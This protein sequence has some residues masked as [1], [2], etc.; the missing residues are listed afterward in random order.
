MQAD[1]EFDIGGDAPVI[2]AHWAGFVDLRLQ[3]ERAA[4][5]IEAAAF[6][7][8]AQALR[9][10]NAPGSPVWTSKCDFFP[11]LAPDEFDAI[12]LDAHPSEAAYAMAC[13]IDLLAVNGAR[14]SSPESV[15]VHC[16]AIC[17]RLWAISLCCCRADLVIRRAIVEPDRMELGIT[18][19]PSACGPTPDAA[20]SALE[21][22]LAALTDSVVRIASTSASTDVTL[23]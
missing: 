16:E 21:A 7:A 4:T 2:E 6:P 19:Y 8:L 23:E 3:P 9:T 15:R 17:S 12:E 1:S 22:A 11:R 20:S 14:W 10:L 5:L 13:Y 18:A